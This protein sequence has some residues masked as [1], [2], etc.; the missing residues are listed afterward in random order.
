MRLSPIQKIIANSK[1][2][3]VVFIGGRRAGKS[4]YSADKTARVVSKPFSNVIYICLTYNNARDN[5][6]PFF[7]RVFSEKKWVKSIN[8]TNFIIEFKNGST[9]RIRSSDKEDNLRGPAYDLAIFDEFSYMQE[10]IWSK[11]IRPM[12]ADSQGEALFVSTPNG[13]HNWARDLYDKGLSTDPINSNW[14]S[15]KFTTLEGGFIPESEI[16][17]AKNEL[18]IKSFKQEYEADF[19]ADSGLVYYTF[20]RTKYTYSKLIPPM[21]KYT[22]ISNLDKMRKYKPRIHVGM[23]FNVNPM[24]A[25]IAVKRDGVFYVDD[26]VVIADSN[27]TEMAREIEER[28]PYYEKHCYP[29]ASGSARSTNSGKSDHYI[30]SQFGWKL[31]ARLANPPVKDRIAAVNSAFES[32]NG[33]NKLKVNINCKELIRSLERQVYKEGTRQPEKDGT[34]HL[35]DALGYMIYNQEPVRP[36]LVQSGQVNLY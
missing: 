10:S 7:K 26:E 22:K 32:M 31:H 15:F 27:T 24:S 3:F 11:V 12:L 21:K 13:I 28:Y 4:R 17:E 5:M 8:N 18:D 33:V 1:A 20:D 23:D 30:L 19:V 29:D 9:L 2:R 34:D 6:W 16:E 25:V 36:R 14:E 35:N